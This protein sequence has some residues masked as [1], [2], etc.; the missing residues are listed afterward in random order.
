M[1]L[2]YNNDEF[3]AI[4]ISVYIYTYNVMDIKN[5]IVK[6]LFEVYISRNSKNENIILINKFGFLCDINKDNNY[7]KE[8]AYKILEENMLTCVLDK[9][10]LI[11]NLKLIINNINDTND[12][13]DINDILMQMATYKNDIKYYCNRNIYINYITE[14]EYNCEKIISNDND[15]ANDI[16]EIKKNLI[17]IIDKT[18]VSTYNLDYTIK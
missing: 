10:K 15:N 2:I 6:Q 12:I 18:I 3:A 11:Q 13:I 5:N 17:N 1:N 7:Y 16:N 8:Y 9:L 4:I 14:I